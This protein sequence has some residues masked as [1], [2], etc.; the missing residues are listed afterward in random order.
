MKNPKVSQ[1]QV[2]NVPVTRD[3]I[4]AFIKADINSLYSLSYE[5]LTTPEAIDV[6]ADKLYMKYLKDKSEKESKEQEA[7]HMVIPQDE[8]V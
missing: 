6:L 4:K 7:I 5:L 8:N 3:S 1:A 2:K